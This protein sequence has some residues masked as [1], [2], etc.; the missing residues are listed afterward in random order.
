L[1]PTLSVI[2]NTVFYIR[3]YTIDGDSLLGGSLVHGTGG[4]LSS[5][6]TLVLSNS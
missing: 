1:Q 2:S 6:A 3:D 5:T 4:E